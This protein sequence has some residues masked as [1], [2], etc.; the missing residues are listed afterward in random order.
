MAEEGLPRANQ[1]WIS[2]RCRGGARRGLLVNSLLKV[3]LM[4]VWFIL[5]GTI[6]SD[7]VGCRR[8]GVYIC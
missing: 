4:Y 2:R 6:D 8:R 1:G 3:L 5:W 7:G